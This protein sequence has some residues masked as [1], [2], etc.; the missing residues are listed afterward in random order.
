MHKELRYQGKIQEIFD[1]P[2]KEKYDFMQFHPNF[3]FFFTITCYM[4]MTSYNKHARHD[5]TGVSSMLPIQKNSHPTY[6]FC[7]PQIVPA[8]FSQKK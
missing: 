6:F 4:E 3:F 7:L 2:R 8:I 1:M 5:Q